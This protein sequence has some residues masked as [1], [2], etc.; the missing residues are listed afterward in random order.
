MTP[1]LWSFSAGEECFKKLLENGADPNVV[2]TSHFGVPQAILPGVSVTHMAAGTNFPNYFK[3]VMEHGGDPNLKNPN[4][5][6]QTPIFTTISFRKMENVKLLI[7]KG[8]NLNHDIGYTPIISAAMENKY[9]IVL[10]LLEEGA[11]YKHYRTK[12]N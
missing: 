3:L 9:D 2:V 11:D 6:E 7:E 10:L 5:L 1:L 12:A 8:A 4:L